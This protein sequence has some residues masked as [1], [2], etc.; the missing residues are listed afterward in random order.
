M[1]GEAQK[2]WLE[3]SLAESGA[4]LKIIAIG[5]QVLTDYHHY[6]SYAMFA[7]ERRE[8]LEWIRRRRIE[9][10]VFVDGDRHL[11][12]LMRAE[13]RRMYPLYELTASPIANRP[14]PGG[15]EQ[16]NPIRLAVY[17]DGDSYGVLE[18]DTTV[19][20]ARLTFLVKDAEGREVV[21]HETTLD[22]L[23]FGR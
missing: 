12:E 16:P 19:A 21:R 7:Y 22:E 5:H 10:V 15:L 9:G 3:R 14:F 1:L 17:A 4:P 18:L 20:P 23:R 13:E 11:S 8:I 6:E 2:A